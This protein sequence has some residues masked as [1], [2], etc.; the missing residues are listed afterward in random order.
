MVDVN[1][2]NTFSYYNNIFK[3][4]G[5]QKSAEGEFAA[6]VYVICSKIKR[7]INLSSITEKQKLCDRVEK[8]NNTKCFLFEER[9]MNDKTWKKIADNKLKEAIVN[10]DNINI[11]KL[12]NSI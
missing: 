9:Y 1:L 6:Q 2:K 3:M 7:K 11:S 5:L 10:V 8:W 12:K 4:N